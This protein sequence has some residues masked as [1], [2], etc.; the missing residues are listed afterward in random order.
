MHEG[1]WLCMWR[2]GCCVY[3]DGSV[4]HVMGVAVVCVREVLVLCELAGY[5]CVCGALLCL[6]GGVVM[7]VALC[8]H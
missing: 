4:M 1:V 8:W 7:H 5:C 6:C 3:E 2:G